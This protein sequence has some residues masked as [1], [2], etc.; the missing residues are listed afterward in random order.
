M[1]LYLPSFRTLDILRLGLLGL[2][3][4]PQQTLVGGWA[5]GDR[6]EAPMSYLS[7]SS[8]PVVR[9][10]Q[11][12][13]G[14]GLHLGSEWCHPRCFSPLPP[15]QCQRLCE[16]DTWPLVLGAEGRQGSSSGR[17]RRTE[18]SCWGSKWRQEKGRGERTNLGL[19]ATVCS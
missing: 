19:K 13:E 4:T 8:M 3:P 14:L 16:G 2:F 18:W 9:R 10:E 6:Y 5:G 12:A 17:G 11:H 1:V 15:A 7:A